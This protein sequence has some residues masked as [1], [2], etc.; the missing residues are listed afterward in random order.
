MLF[1]LSTPLSYSVI[2]P[3]AR[4]ISRDPN[5]EVM[6]TARWG[7][8]RLARELLDFPFRWVTPLLAPLVATEVA[9]CPGFHFRS[10]RA[11]QL[12]EMF[13]GASPKNYAVRKEA[14]RFDRL[15]LIGEYHRRKFVRTGVLREDDPKGVRVGMPKTDALLGDRAAGR[16]LLARL[17]L[18]PATP[19][20]AY[21]PTRSGDHGSSLERFGADVIDRLAQLPTNVLVKLHDRSL[22]RFRR[23]LATD[24]SALVVERARGSRVRLVTDHDVTPVLLAADVLVSD[25]SSVA[26]EFLLRDRPIVFLPVERHE[27]KLKKSMKRR[28]G[29][30]DPEDL[31]WLRGGGE[32]VADVAGLH[33]AIERA[34]ADP[35][36]LRA[37]R[38]ERAD[39]LF[40][41][42]GRA[43][44][45]AVRELRTM[46]GLDAP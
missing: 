46:I 34:L 18:D 22:P 37:E 42:H 12:V 20:V 16:A 21:C 29:G 6:I 39:R 24:W 1:P 41:N 9:V 25:L 43:T 17:G 14:R 8:K 10:R 2:A 38:R 4:E 33:G 36:A 35:A 27:K 7:G 44:S 30:D 28:F 15:F 40:Y 23:G 3:V 32:V 5:V 45:C 26:N 13:H 11:A 31:D 19:T